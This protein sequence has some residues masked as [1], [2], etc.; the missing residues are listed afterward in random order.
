MKGIK[1]FEL[2]PDLERE[3]QAAK[4]ME[5]ITVFY[6]T[7]VVVI[8]YLAMG[9]S[10]AMKTAWLED[11]LSLVPSIAFLIATRINTKPPD[12]KFRYGYHRVFSI[13]FLIGAAGLLGMGIFLVYDSSISLFM[14]EHPTIGNRLFF[15]KQIW[16]GWIMIAALLYSSVP[17]M[18]IGFKKLPMAKK[19]HNKTLY[20]D[21]EAQK[22]DYMTAFAGIIGVLAVGAGIWWADAVAALF[23]SFSITYNGFKYFSEAVEDLMDRYPVT[24]GEQK[25]DPLVEEVKQLVLSWDWV[26]DARVRFREDGQVYLGEIAVIPKNAVDL[27]ELEKSYKILSAYHWKINDVS[28]APVKKL[29]DW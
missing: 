14:A 24:L 20:T 2:P 11:L 17:A 15:G 1:A 21:A 18:I 6:L 9:S 4:K 12:D 8:M 19:L 23:I 29:P 3:L 25:E 26:Q 28:I 16:L 5:W 7:S 27:D 10:Q 22:A 13:A